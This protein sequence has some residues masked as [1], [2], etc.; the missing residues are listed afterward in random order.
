MYND[1]QYWAGWGSQACE[2]AG[3]NTNWPQKNWPS[4]LIE[5]VALPELV[6]THVQMAPWV[7]CKGGS[8]RVAPGADHTGTLS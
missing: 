5:A 3:W 6:W 1:R 2:G 8:R 7:L 4:T